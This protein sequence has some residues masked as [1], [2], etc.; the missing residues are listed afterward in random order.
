MSIKHLEWKYWTPC[1]VNLSIIFIKHKSFIASRNNNDSTSFPTKITET[2]MP[3][4]IAGGKYFKHTSTNYRIN[5]A[6]NQIQLTSVVV[7]SANNFTYPS[8]HREPPSTAGAKLQ[9]TAL[10]GN[11]DYTLHP[12]RATAQGF[13]ERGH[14][15][16]VQKR[17]RC[18]RIEGKAR[19]KTSETRG[20]WSK[21]ANQRREERNSQRRERKSDTRAVDRR[22]KRRTKGIEG[23]RK[24]VGRKEGGVDDVFQRFPSLD[25]FVSRWKS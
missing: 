10:H 1:I 19:W 4:T 21:Q 6:N 25:T 18:K 15:R 16:K 11:T 17:R 9:E 8:R 3:L 14:R 22:K 2:A 20:K 7:L 24:G 23:V 5:R 13:K 12:S